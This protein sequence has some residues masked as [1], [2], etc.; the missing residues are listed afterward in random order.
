MEL[1]LAALGDGRRVFDQPRRQVDPQVAQITVGEV[2]FGEKRERMRTRLLGRQLATIGG[3][4]GVEAGDSEA[5]LRAGGKPGGADDRGGGEKSGATGVGGR[6]GHRARPRPW[7]LPLPWWRGWCWRWRGWCSG[8]LPRPSARVGGV[9]SSGS[10]GSGWQA[11]PT[12]SI[13]L[14]ESARATLGRSTPPK[15]MGASSRTAAAKKAALTG[16]GGP[17]SAFALAVL[18]GLR[19]ATAVLDE[20]LEVE[21]G[22]VLATHRHVGPVG[23]LAEVAAVDQEALLAALHRQHELGHRGVGDRVEAGADAAVLGV[24]PAD[25][26][27]VDLAVQ[28]DDQVG[29]RVGGGAQVDGAFQGLVEQRRE[30]PGVAVDRALGALG[31][32]AGAG[33]ELDAGAD[34]ADVVLVEE[35]RVRQGDRGAWRCWRRRGGLVRV[36]LS[37]G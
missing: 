10:G 25:Q 18:L 6:A 33:G 28:G 27:D 12:H 24:D 30:G 9:G 34:G 16:I 1:S 2:D 17:L 35:L 23:R 3:G 13:S 29:Q 15:P 22:C 5:R 32:V 31:A 4:A 26:V 19:L 36:A 21:A 37:A 20:R 11:S 7:P 14:E 8:G